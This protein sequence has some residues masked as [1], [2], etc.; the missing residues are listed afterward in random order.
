MLSVDAIF[1]QRS[2]ENKRI[3][4]FA[5]TFIDVVPIDHNID[6]KAY[7]ISLYKNN[8][9]SLTDVWSHCCYKV[10]DATRKE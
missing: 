7:D 2:E 3:N 10:R 4:L 8:I 1:G 9:V 6:V 5:E